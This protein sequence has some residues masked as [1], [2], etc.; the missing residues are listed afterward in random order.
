MVVS[1]ILSSEA[2]QPVSGPRAQRSPQASGHVEVR[3]GDRV[4]L[5][6]SLRPDEVDT[7][8]RMGRSRSGGAQDPSS[9]SPMA[10]IEPNP[11][12]PPARND[13]PVI[14]VHGTMADAQ[15]IS[16]Y[17]QPDL[18]AGHPVNL[19]TY[20]TIK[21]GEPLQVSGQLVS[22]DINDSRIEMTRKH[23]SDLKSLGG[24]TEAIMAFLC[25]DGSLYGKP[26]PAFDR[27]V[28][29]LP[30]VIDRL[31]GI[32]AADKQALLGSFSSQTR[33]LEQDL[34]AQV[35]DTGFASSIKDE[36][37]RGEVCQKVAAEI[38]DSIA[39]KA[40]LVG[41]S[42]GG[43]VSYV[44]TV[45]PRQP[46][47]K[48]TEFT[49]DG[50]N[51]VST[52]ITLSSPIKSGVSQPLPPALTHFA[53]DTYEKTLLAPVESTPGMQ[54]ALL[55]PG[56]A[57]WYSMQK[58]TARRASAA[59]SNASAQMMNPFIYAKQPGVEQISAGSPFIRTYV[60]G[61]KVPAGVTGVAFT[62][63]EDQISEASRSVLDD[64]QP[65]AFN[66]DA[67]VSVTSE[68]LRQNGAT[69]RNIPHMRMAKGPQDRGLEFKA[70]VLENSRQIPRVLYRC[71]YDGVRW[72]CVN[73]LL[74]TLAKDPALFQ[75]PGMA[76]VLEAVREVASEKLPFTDSP[77][78]VAQQILDQLA[79]RGA[80]TRAASSAMSRS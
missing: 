8:V 60:D 78:Y 16:P 74:G 73:S 1:R 75:R 67:R 80:G 31:D 68:M 71:N 44:L 24:D 34:A 11:D 43:F 13:T 51:G 28:A 32:L 22:R 4:Q 47:D 26:D 5:G 55:N 17:L 38:L 33:Q 53:F 69:F 64:S 23:L 45:N 18:D 12:V 65:N 76:P 56:F 15:S 37:K 46:G 3:A 52:V 25:M 57:A 70:Q 27:V 62:C 61:K 30:G 66:V 79:H 63:Q 54:F 2:V 21:E 41:H 59:M 48:G 10:L 42:M 40:I 58:E 39:P 6:T 50:G 9:I 14:V 72:Q 49:Y 20:S 19:E 36:T 7:L 77:S 29:L 35:A